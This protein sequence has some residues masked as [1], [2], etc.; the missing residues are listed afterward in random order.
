MLYL[1]RGRTLNW[2]SYT[3]RIPRKAYTRIRSS[4]FIQTITRIMLGLQPSRR[5]QD[6]PNK[7]RTSFEPNTRSK[8]KALRSR[9][10]QTL[11]I[12]SK[13]HTLF[14]NFCSNNV[15]NLASPGLIPERF[16]VE[17]QQ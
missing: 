3:A 17:K 10:Y 13:I 2:K 11:V 12:Q 1:K 5:S 4:S 14:G 8:K 9:R 16:K 15:L 7:K 6:P